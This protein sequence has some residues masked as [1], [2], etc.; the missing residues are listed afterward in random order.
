M[1]MHEKSQGV[2]DTA[3][4]IVEM[5]AIE[6]DQKG[7]TGAVGAVIREIPRSIVMPIVLATRATNNMLS[8]VKN[9]LVP[10]AQIEAKEKYKEDDD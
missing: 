9:Q 7:V 10:E 4:N 5:A 2:G 8:G 1:A 3:Q 6:H